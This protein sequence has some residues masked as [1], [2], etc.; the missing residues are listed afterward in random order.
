MPWRRLA[1]LALAL[2][3][4]GALSAQAAAQRFGKD[5]DDDRGG[6][7]EWILLG[8]KTV[9]LKVDRDVIDLRQAEDWYKTRAFRRL[10]LV[11]ENNDI[12]LLSLRLVYMNGSDENFPVDRLIRD[13]QDQPI[14]LR[15]ERKYLKRIELIYRSRPSVEGRAVMKVYGEPARFGGPPSEL[16]PI[17]G[18]PG[19]GSEWVELGC[20]RVSLFGVDRDAIEVGRREGRFKAI[21]LSAQGADIQMLDLTVVYGNGEPDHI[22]VRSKLR[23]GDRTRPLDLRGRGRSINRI[24]MTYVTIPNFKGQARVCA[25]GLQ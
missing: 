9:R 16:P 18:G 6:R 22:P 24:E 13:G 14:D 20:K 25:E 11:A 7:A 15:G 12:H 17:S 21:R 5:R 1:A 23:Q 10:H 4:T 8:E 2:A 19:G 3:L